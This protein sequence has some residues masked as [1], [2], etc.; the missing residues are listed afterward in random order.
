MN[1][2]FL[3]CALRAHLTPVLAHLPLCVKQRT[4]PLTE[5]TSAEVTRPAKIY[6]GDVWPKQAGAEENVPFLCLQERGGHDEESLTR[7][8]ILLRCAVYSPEPETAV[9]ELSTLVSTVRHALMPLS[10]RPLEARYRLLTDEKNR[11]LAWET[12]TE[13]NHPYAEAY[14]LSVW[15]YKSMEG[16]ML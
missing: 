11:L 5:K 6:I 4:Q 9:H 13:Q 15:E 3:Q 8:E 10:L 12:P 16:V 2:Y 7:V 14:I 1:P